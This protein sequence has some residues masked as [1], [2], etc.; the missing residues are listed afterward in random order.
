[1]NKYIKV[2][3]SVLAI[4]GYYLLLSTIVPSRDPYFLLGI[5]VIGCVAW[6]LGT[7]AGLV[8]AALLTPLTFYIYG[9]FEVAFSYSGFALSPPYIGIQLFTAITIGSLS[10]RLDRLS[11]KEGSLLQANENLQSTLM[12][13]R[14]M[15]GIHSLCTSCK[16]ILDD[17]GSWK[18]IDT[19][20]KDK[21]K[22]EFSHGLCPE[23]AGEYELPP[24][25]KAEP[26]LKS[27]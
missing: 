20:L 2:I 15:G 5:G 3:L 23:C 10:S 17:D 21:T 16:S 13:V 24:V 4:A 22:V 12:Q 6:M 27:G 7:A 14:E 8:T 1:M 9:Q 11:N 19:Y 26:S 18:K 25:Q